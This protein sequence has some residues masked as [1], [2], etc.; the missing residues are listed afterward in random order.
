MLEA[1][2]NVFDTI[3]IA[4]FGLSCLI[5]F[6]RGFMREMLSLGAWVGAGLITV[7]AFPSVAAWLQ[8]KVNHQMVSVGLAALGTYIISLIVIS[9]FNSLLVKYAK[10]GADV[11][12]MD[13]ALG[14]LFGALRGAFIVSL[15]YLLMSYAMDE[16]NMPEA[17][18]AA[19]TQPFAREGAKLLARIAPQY[20]EEMTELA[21][22]NEPTE[23]ENIDEGTILVPEESPAPVRDGVSGSTP[24]ESERE[25]LKNLYER[26][27]DQTES[28]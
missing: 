1:Q 24:Q 23:T 5:A 27:S 4:V 21:E 19:V 9:G 13:N 11:G 28:E 14:L 25:T 12:M 16:D 2:L 6:F 22:E 17:V 15:G 20:L 26:L 18:K 10:D 7:Y 8:P 3:V